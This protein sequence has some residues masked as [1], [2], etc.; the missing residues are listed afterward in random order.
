[1]EVHVMSTSNVSSHAVIVEPIT[2]FSPFEFF[3]DVIIPLF[4][5]FSWIFFPV[6]STFNFT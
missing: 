5:K 3:V 2:I 1:M 6:K 4:F